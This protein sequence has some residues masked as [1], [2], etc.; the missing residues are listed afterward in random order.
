MEEIGQ[1][2]TATPTLLAT[3]LSGLEPFEL[4]VGPRDPLAVRALEIFSRNSCKT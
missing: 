1:W 2:P 4:A 3:H